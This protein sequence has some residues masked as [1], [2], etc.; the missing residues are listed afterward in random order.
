MGDGIM[1]A[2]VSAA[3][4]VRCAAVIRKE[5]ARHEVQQA[6]EP[7]QIRIGI[8][9]GEPVE[10]QG[11]FF[12]STVQLAARLCA[13]ADPGQTLV[14][15]AVTELCAGTGLRFQDIGDVVLKGFERPVRAHAVLAV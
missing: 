11:D 8:D 2:F 15:T 3:Q 10:R 9:S 14:S 12:G 4:A 1:A 6:G 7:V 5:L 13:R